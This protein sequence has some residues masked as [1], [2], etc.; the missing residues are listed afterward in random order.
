MLLFNLPAALPITQRYYKNI[1]LGKDVM[2]NVSIT[3][4]VPAA[5][6]SPALTGSGE[7]VGSGSGK[8][9]GA[10]TAGGGSGRIQQLTK[11]IQEL[12]Q[13]LRDLA[14]SGGSPEEIKKQ[15]ELIQ[16]QIKALQAEIAR[17]RQ[18][19]MEQTQQ[20]QLDKVGKTGDGVNR[21]TDENQ[22]DVYI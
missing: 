21:P 18:Q 4:A 12:Q 7:S 2:A 11:Q 22:I 8:T 3:M 14:N 20:N 9:V 6:K 1:S 19:E 16:A 5:G 13:Q 10:S 17:I 15:Q